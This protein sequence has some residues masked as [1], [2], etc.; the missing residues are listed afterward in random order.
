MRTHRLAFAAVTAAMLALASTVHAQAPVAGNWIAE[1]ELGMRN[2]NGVITS[3]GT[4]KA[5]V[6]LTLKGDSVFGTWQ[7]LE[8]A[9]TAN[10][11]ARAL[12]GVLAN[13]VLKLESDV[14]ERRV[15]R[16]DEE[17]SLKMITRYEVKLEGD[18]MTGTS[19]NVALGGEFSPPARPFKA[20]REKSL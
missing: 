7:N 19:Q 13:G 5:R 14:E 15:R 10:A 16:N 9:E 17:T 1:F 12:K 20:T 6:A 8:P 11:P 2:E 4:G 3:M 18:V